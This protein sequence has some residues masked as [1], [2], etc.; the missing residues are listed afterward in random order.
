MRK[1][2]AVLVYALEA[3]TVSWTPVEEV[4]D[5]WCG[6][7]VRMEAPRWVAC[8]SLVE[9]FAMTAVHITLEECESFDTLQ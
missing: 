1:L 9:K 4:C 8:S 6:A 3:E 5:F 2:T 7:V